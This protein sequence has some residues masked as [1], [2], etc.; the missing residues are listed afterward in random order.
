MKAFIPGNS[1]TG[2]F[3]DFQDV[4]VL[5]NSRKLS[6]ESVEKIVQIL[7][8]ANEMD[9]VELHTLKTLLAL[10]NPHK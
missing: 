7:N 4:R 3:I 10:V 5:N 9:K 2:P 6:I 1:V 8:T